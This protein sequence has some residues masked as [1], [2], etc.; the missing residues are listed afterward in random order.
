MFDG[1]GKDR[2]TGDAIKIA[3]D[4]QYRALTEGFSVQRFWHLAKLLAIDALLPPAPGELVLDVGC[5][6]GVVSSFLGTYG[7]RVM[8]IDAN[9]NAVA[10]A[11][12]A[13]ASENVE[14][15]CGP[16]DEGV[17]PYGRGRVDRIYCLELIEH[18]HMDQA[19]RMLR[20]FRESLKPGGSV[21]L[22]TPNYHSPWPA[23]EW[24]MDHSG[25]FPV[26]A[27]QQHVEFYHPRKLRSLC[28]RS[29]FTVRALTTLNLLSPW[30]A[31]LGRKLARKVFDMEMRRRSS[32]GPVLTAVLV[33]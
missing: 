10:F 16:A 27:E 8:G 13:F 6:S 2:R 31:P 24:I 4:Y 30:T 14:F 22:T 18:I 3:G 28:L 15:R 7:A 17:S 23:V 19:E 26:M 33:V 25:L 20:L 5:G 11:D 21:F 1:R 12:A 29:G 32:F 9:P